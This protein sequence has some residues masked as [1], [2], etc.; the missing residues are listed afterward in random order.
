MLSSCTI[1]ASSD[2]SIKNIK[3]NNIQK[4]IKETNVKRIY[5][6]GKKAYDIYQKE[7]FP[8]TK[9]E[10]IYLPSSSPANAAYSL[11]K[12]IKDYQVIKKSM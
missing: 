4:L 2:A 6:T 11:E 10:A 12:L 5:T 7:V 3:V 8:K 1:D 9:I